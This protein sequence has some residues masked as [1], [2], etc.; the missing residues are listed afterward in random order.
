MALA[1]VLTCITLAIAIPTLCGRG[2]RAHGP[3]WFQVMPH[4]TQSQKQKTRAQ[5]TQRHGSRRY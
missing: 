3:T 4:L 1:L 5:Q 2:T